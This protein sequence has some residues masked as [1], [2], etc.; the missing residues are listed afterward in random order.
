MMNRKL[1]RSGFVQDSL[2][3]ITVSDKQRNFLSTIAGRTDSLAHHAVTSV[4]DAP[5]IYNWI[6]LVSVVGIPKGKETPRPAVL[7][8]ILMCLTYQILIKKFSIFYLVMIASK[9]PKPY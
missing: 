7:S 4:A 9:Q 6:V 5:D 3:R 1:P 2:S 8:Y